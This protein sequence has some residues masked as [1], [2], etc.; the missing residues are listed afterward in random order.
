MKNLVT[1]LRRITADVETATIPAGKVLFHGTLETFAGGL[2]GGGYDNIIWFSDSPRIAQLYI[3]RAGMTSHLDAETISRPTKDVYL[4]NLQKLI[5]IDYDLEDVEWDRNRATS[6]SAP[7]GWDKLPKEADVIRLMKESGWADERGQFKIKFNKDK[8]LKPGEA[9]PGRLFIA[10]VKEPLTVWVKA[11]GD[12]DLQDL[13]YH[14]LKGFK[15]AE[16]Q[17]LDGVVIDDF[18]QS[19]VEGNFGHQSLGMFSDDKLQIRE[20]PAQYREWDREAKGTPE[21]PNEPPGFLH[22]L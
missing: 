2:K 15:A 17:G 4:Q 8:P 1:A 13:Q 6:F 19:E 18:A 11:T 16:A 12:G 9:S 22:K 10:K 5:G 20:V 3:P 14:D 21:Y 7:K